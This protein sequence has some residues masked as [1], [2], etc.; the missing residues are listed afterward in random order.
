MS[1]LQITD[2]DHEKSTTCRRIDVDLDEAPVTQ[3]IPQVCGDRA[4]GG[5][6]PIGARRR[7]DR[8]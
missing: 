6:R 5:C 8:S 7:H 1:D 3:G 4:D 2:V